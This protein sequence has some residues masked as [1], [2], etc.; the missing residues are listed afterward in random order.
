MARKPR[1]W[2]PGFKYHIYSRGIRKLPL[3]LDDGNRNKYLNLIKEIKEAYPF[4]IH[5]YCLMTN[6]TH[7]QLETIDTSPSIIMSQLNTKYARYFNKKYHYSGHLFERR[8]NAEWI[9]S[10]AYE[11]D[12]SKYIHLNPVKA[13]IVERPEDYPWSSCRAYLLGE[14][15][16]LIG[17]HQIFS[18]FPNPSS[19]HYREFLEKPFIDEAAKQF[20]VE[21]S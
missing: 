7:L 16:S 17:T 3:F 12:L 10:A 9:D 8:F 15:N 13:G 6:H 18:Y 1:V 19:Q 14:P 11:L 2:L 4:I 20:T 21:F 5:T